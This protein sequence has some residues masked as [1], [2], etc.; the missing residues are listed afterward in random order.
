MSSK[1]VLLMIDTVIENTVDVNKLICIGDTI[2]LQAKL[3]ENGV[4][5]NLTG[6]SVTLIIKKS[7]GTLVENSLLTS[8]NNEINKILSDQV[9]TFPGKLEGQ[10]TVT[11]Q[12][13]QRCSTNIFTM[14]V[15]NIVGTAKL[16]TSESDIQSLIDLTN[17]ITQAN[18]AIKIYGDSADAIAGTK[19]AIEA[20][21]AI[22]EYY[23]T[24]NHLLT[25]NIASAISVNGNLIDKTS[26]ANT[27]ITNLTNQNNKAKENI[28]ALEKYGGIDDLVQEIT[29]ARGEYSTLNERLYNISTSIG[30][31][32]LYK[33]YDT[34]DIIN[35]YVDQS[36]GSDSTGD[37][38]R[39]KPY[40]TVEK[41]WEQIPYFYS[42]YFKI[43]IVGNYTGDIQLSKKE[44]LLEKYLILTS[45]DKSLYSITS[46]IKV[47]FNSG[48]NYRF[49]NMNIMGKITCL[50]SNIEISRCSITN[51][52][53]D[54]SVYCS[55][56]NASI[57]YS[58]ISN[59]YSS[60]VCIYATKN[61]YVDNYDVKLS[62]EK[63]IVSNNGSIVVNRYQV[64]NS[65]TTQ[66]EIT[67]GGQIV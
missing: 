6:E 44:S 23:N 27:T 10:L 64:T 60:G 21:Q 3:Y 30:N 14:E 61:S 5:K 34:A 29:D 26:E 66:T 32:P 1:N 18:N 15:K 20:L 12:L 53:S 58:D 45:D 49:L 22:Q 62:G 52:S 54:F 65:C 13:G 39:S 35:Y 16:P 42:N 57:E 50:R 48:N 47:N 24:N 9:T 17:L 51:S 40:A 11:N 36:N 19:D 56:S 38:T 55:A 8:G 2:N 33:V 25:Q 41:A 37:G 63:G 28:E 67:Y 31:S 4:A 43:I 7:D 59:T 46:A